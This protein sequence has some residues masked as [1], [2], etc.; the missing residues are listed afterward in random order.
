MVI[1]HVLCTAMAI[2]NSVQKAMN[3]VVASRR[4]RM[5]ATWIAEAQK[6]VQVHVLCPQT[7][8]CNVSFTIASCTALWSP[9]PAKAKGQHRLRLRRHKHYVRNYKEL[10]SHDNGTQLWR[11]W[12][13]VS[14]SL[15]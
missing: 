2:N 8:R 15:M 14:W 1:D 10:A 12:R 4:L 6:I 13:N 7:P 11:A 5:A 9:H 3:H